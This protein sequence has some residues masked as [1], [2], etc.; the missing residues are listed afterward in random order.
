M[1]EPNDAEP[2][3]AVDPATPPAGAGAGAADT[4]PPAGGL[5]AAAL[6]RELAQARKD[7]AT[8]RKRAQALEDEKKTDSEKQAEELTRLREQNAALV[9]AQRDANVQLATAAIAQR[10][11]FKNPDIA[12]RLLGGQ[13]E[14]DESGNPKNIERL[15]TEVAKAYPYLV[16][17]SAD[18]GQ[19][20][21]SG[22][23]SGANVDDMIRTAAR[24]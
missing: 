13:V 16:N 24:R 17:G 15:L 23:P 3:P 14:F 10:L 21:R 22:P 7:A 2:T 20:P 18:L 1:T 8:Y 11:G 19:G 6:E 12:F 5:D 4:T 9:A